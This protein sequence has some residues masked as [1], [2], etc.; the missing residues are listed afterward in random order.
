MPGHGWA[1][2]MTPARQGAAPQPGSRE[3]GDQLRTAARAAWLYHSRGLKQSEVA[4][5][6]AISQSSVSRL[7]EFAA[8]RGIVRTIVV[9][10]PELNLDL[11][12]ALAER[13]GLVQCHVFDLG[14][15]TDEVAI[16]RDL[17]RAFATRLDS[18]PLTARTIGV[19]SWSRSL[20]A[21]VRAMRPVAESSA[22]YVVEM[23]GDV[24]PP[25]VQHEAAALTEQLAAVTG[26]EPRYLRMPG[27]MPSAGARERA[28]AHDAHARDALDRLGDVDLAL[29]GIGTCRIVDPLTAGGNF[30]TEAQFE[31]ARSLG[32]VGEVNLHFIAEDGSPVATDLDDLVVGVTLQQLTDCPRVAAVGGGPSKHQAILAALRAGPINVFATDVA[33]AEH[34]LRS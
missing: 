24:G 18:A 25:A 7:L 5:Q 26:A 32:A 9:P 14:G 30:F 23:L 15:E 34:L 19:T 10:P 12:H 20:R 21:A 33:T 6:L 11:E 31:H 8:S 4:T 1:D 2:P 3:D 13:F 22:E 17:G 27:V 16:T 28:L 29:V